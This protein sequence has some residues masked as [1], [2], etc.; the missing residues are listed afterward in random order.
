MGTPI[1]SR[2]KPWIFDWTIKPDA[3]MVSAIDFLTSPRAFKQLEKKGIR[4]ILDWDGL[5]ICD[6][7]AFSALNRKNKITIELEDLKGLYI[8]LNNQD[9]NIFKITLDYPDDKIISNYNKLHSLEVYP[10]LPYNQLDLINSITDIESNLRWIFIGRLVPLMRS[11]GGHGNKLFP[12]IEEIRDFFSEKNL[13]NTKIW[14]L[15]VGAPSLM[16]DLQYLVDGCDSARW[17]ITGSNMILL[18]GGG[19]R[20]VGKK[21][22]WRGTHNRISEGEEKEGIIRTLLMI[23]QNSNGLE[24]LDNNLNPSKSVKAIEADYEM[25]LPTI[26]ELLDKLRKNQ[27]KISPKDLEYLF[28]SSGNLRLLFNFWVALSFKG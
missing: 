22:K 28:R 18:P 11:G 20:G 27:D 21:T 4:E 12:I 19:E 5:L 24:L 23:D 15:G 3:L 13:K 17:R 1:F 26:G 10:V 7:G 8:E 9:P 25:K 6:S 16:Q 14:A 2:F